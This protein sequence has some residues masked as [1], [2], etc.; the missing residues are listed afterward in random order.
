M[1]PL[2]PV[3]T[4]TEPV[5]TPSYWYVTRVKIIEKKG[6]LTLKPMESINITNELTSAESVGNYRFPDQ[7]AHAKFS[8]ARGT[9]TL[10][11]MGTVYGRP[12]TKEELTVVAKQA[13]GFDLSDWED[14]TDYPERRVVAVPGR[15]PPSFAPQPFA[16]VRR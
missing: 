3:K 12:A 4:S 10:I 6:V 2:E 1:N 13:L 9:D 7:N 15:K 14:L 8:C 16:A 5:E 11:I